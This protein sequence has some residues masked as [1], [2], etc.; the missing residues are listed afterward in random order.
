MDAIVLTDN[1]STMG[2]VSPYF[3]TRMRPEYDLL[4]CLP[5]CVFHD[6][7]GTLYT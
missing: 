2:L 7:Y 6:L 5:G 1:R 3:P 4:R